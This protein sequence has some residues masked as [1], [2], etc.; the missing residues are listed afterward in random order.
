MIMLKEAIISEEPGW[1]W[2]MVGLTITP[3]TPQHAISFLICVVCCS[4]APCH[5]LI[6]HN[7]CWRVTNAAGGCARAFSLLLPHA[8]EKLPILKSQ[9]D[10]LSLSVSASSV[11]TNLEIII[12]GNMVM[13][14][15]FCSPTVC[16]LQR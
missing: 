5:A 3:K 11:W 10:L 7:H 15:Q 14:N 13:L 1:L 4:V 12:S 8:V 6:T 2:G 9:S 16:L